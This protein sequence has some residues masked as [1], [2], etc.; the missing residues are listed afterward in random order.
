MKNRLLF[1]GKSA[2]MKAKKQ[3]EQKT[4]EENQKKALKND[5]YRLS[6][7][8]YIL[9]AAVEYFIALMVAG[10]YLAKVTSAI[11]MSD[12]MTGILSAFVCNIS[13]LFV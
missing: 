11:G 3:K 8:M 5:P 12:A 2:I 1:R 6:R 4:L 10:A 13:P 9:Q 7:F